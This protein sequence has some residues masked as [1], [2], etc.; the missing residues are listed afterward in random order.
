MQLFQQRDLGNLQMWNDPLNAAIQLFDGC[1]LSQEHVGSGLQHRFFIVGSR[2]HREANHPDVRVLSL[3]PGGRFDAVEAGHID[4]HDDHSRPKCVRH[5]HG[6]MAI[7]G[8]ADDLNVGVRFQDRP[9]TLSHH[10]MIVDEKH[11]ESLLNRGHQIA[12]RL[13]A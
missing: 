2:V 7:R 12:H 10:G 6:F 8:F 5:S 13:L 1:F 9:Q 3:D 4:I 11:C